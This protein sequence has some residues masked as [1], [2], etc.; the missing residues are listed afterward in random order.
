LAHWGL[1]RRKQNKQQQ[2][3]QVNNNLLSSDKVA[4][5]GDF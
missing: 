5:A 4:S 1:L 2:A 3:I